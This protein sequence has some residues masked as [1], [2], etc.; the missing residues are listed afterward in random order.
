MNRLKSGPKTALDGPRKKLLTRPYVSATNFRKLGLFRSLYGIPIGQTLDA[1]MD[2]A[3]THRDFK[4]PTKGRKLNT[5][6]KM[7][8]IDNG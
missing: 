6:N 4:L 2:F 3:S 8:E 1:A 7:E 5:N